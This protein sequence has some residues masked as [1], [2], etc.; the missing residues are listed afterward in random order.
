MDLITRQAVATQVAVTCFIAGAFDRIRN[1]DRGQGSVEYVGI[2]MVVAI[3]IVALIAAINSG[4]ANSLVAKIEEA[5]AK[6]Q[7]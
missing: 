3:L 5:I 6:I 4:I 1:D 2:V 7:G